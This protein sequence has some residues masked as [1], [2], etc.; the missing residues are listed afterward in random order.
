[1]TLVRARTQ[2]ARSGVYWARWP[3]GYRAFHSQLKASLM[4]ELETELD[5][6]WDK[7]IPSRKLCTLD[8]FHYYYSFPL[9]IGSKRY[10]TLKTQKETVIYGVRV[11]W[12]AIPTDNVWGLRPASQNHSLPYSWPKSAIFPAPLMT[13][14]KLQYPIYDRLRLAQLPQT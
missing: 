7:N 4:N 9:L 5:S 3:P 10:R 6:F 1:M 14:P 2:T 8:L 12:G 11:P 13:W